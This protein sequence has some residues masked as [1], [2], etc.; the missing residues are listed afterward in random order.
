MLEI[1]PRGIKLDRQ[2]SSG[3]AKDGPN[4]TRFISLKNIVRF[5]LF[6][7]FKL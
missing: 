1:S 5:V 6:C 3:I 7:F 4:I 2:A